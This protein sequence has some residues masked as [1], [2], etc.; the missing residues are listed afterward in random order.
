MAPHSIPS[1]RTSGG[2]TSGLE[3]DLEKDEEAAI[4]TIPISSKE[5]SPP[6]PDDT[7]TPPSYRTENGKH[8]GPDGTELAPSQT[9]AAILEVRSEERRVGKECPV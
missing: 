2:S 1:S 9:R 5:N 7:P 6:I 8:F 4:D 3:R